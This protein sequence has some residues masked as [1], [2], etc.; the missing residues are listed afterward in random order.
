MDWSIAQKELASSLVPLYGERE[1]AVI[2]DWVLESL[3]GATK[4]DRL[5]MR[6]ELLAAGQLGIYE[7]YR[8]E[9]LA[10]RPVQY[11][12]GE[13][14]F[15]GMKFF[16]DE[17][18][19]IPRPETEEL[20]EWAGS[21]LSG[22]VLD[23]GTGSGC[24]AVTL[25]RRL[26]DVVVS[27]CD[28]SAGALAVAGKNAKELGAEVRLLEL[29]FL[30]RRSWA[31]LPPIRWLVSNPPYIPG[32]ERGTMASHVVD[33]EPD[34]ALFVPGDDALVFYR[35]LGEFARE[36]M[37]PDGGLFAEVHEDRGP[38]VRDLLLGLGAQEVQLRNDLQGK[39]RMIK[40]TW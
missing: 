21:T 20:V 35:L 16:V 2:A 4:L 36:R 30:D 40:A 28:V 13:S 3:S 9:L 18:V 19:L 33:Y 22:P 6:G 37:E 39:D 34:M 23:V 38:A 11:V 12:L 7:R 17:R 27:A 24:I 31:A 1:A 14:W 5:M 32:G 8:R 15:A 10:H 26:P 29:D 25:A